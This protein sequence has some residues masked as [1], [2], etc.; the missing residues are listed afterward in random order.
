MK[1]VK[2]RQAIK[3]G[4]EYFEKHDTVICSDCIDR[5][6]LDHYDWYDIAFEL[7]FDCMEMPEEKP[8]PAEQP[9][10]GQMDMF[11]GVYGENA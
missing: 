4:D 3:S 7:G 1:C 10:K 9:I 2:C 6:I 8:E 11:G 5:Y